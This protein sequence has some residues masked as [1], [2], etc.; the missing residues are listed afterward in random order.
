MQFISV[1]NERTGNTRFNLA[2]V[3]QTDMVQAWYDDYSLVE[4]M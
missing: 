1:Q 4:G 2:Q 3:A